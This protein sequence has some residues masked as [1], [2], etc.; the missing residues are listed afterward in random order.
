M[1]KYYSR[2]STSTEPNEMFNTI[3]KHRQIRT[4]T[5]EYC[6]CEG[7]Q[8]RP[9]E[10]RCEARRSRN[11]ET[12]TPQHQ[13]RAAKSFVFS[14]LR[15]L[16]HCVAKT[17]EPVPLVVGVWTVCERYGRTPPRRAGVVH[18]P[19]WKGG[20]CLAA[21]QD[22]AICFHELKNRRHK[23]SLSQTW[24]CARKLN[25]DLCWNIN[26][27]TPHRWRAQV[28]RAE[29]TGS[30]R[31]LHWI[32]SAPCK[33][34]TEKVGVTSTL[35]RIV[36]EEALKRYGSEKKLSKSTMKRLLRE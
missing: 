15:V 9:D 17:C 14:F 5:I 25:S 10:H 26:R 16:F 29:S 21:P 13:S 28:H 35:L 11:E 22:R 36:S 34:L 18:E 32:L 3:E 2:T 8:W 27:D 4:Q 24:R 6:K 7:P 12:K 1:Q 31:G 20:A 19:G 33:G 23:W 30:R